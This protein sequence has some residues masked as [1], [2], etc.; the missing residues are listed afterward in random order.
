M[1]ALCFGIAYAGE[2]EHIADISS[3]AQTLESKRINE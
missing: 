1:D 3:N 2:G